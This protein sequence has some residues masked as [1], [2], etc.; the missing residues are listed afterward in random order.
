MDKSRKTQIKPEEVR[1]LEQLIGKIKQK[2]LL[3]QPHRRRWKRRPTGKKE[4]YTPEQYEHKKE[5][6]KK[7][8]VGVSGTWKHLRKTYS[9]KAKRLGAEEEWKI[10]LEDWWRLWKAAGTDGQGRTV[11]SHRGKHAGA[12]K[13]WRINCKKPWTLDNVIVAWRGEIRANGRELAK[14]PRDG[15]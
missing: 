9:S 10:S 3:I 11:F 12:A 14:E 6:D 13:V 2:S 15:E 1:D 8:W 7:T 4:E 5:R